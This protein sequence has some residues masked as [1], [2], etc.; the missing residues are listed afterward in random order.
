MMLHNEKQ[1][2]GGEISCKMA[3]WNMERHSLC[4]DIIKMN[5]WGI[6]REGGTLLELIQDRING[7]FGVSGLTDRVTLKE[8]QFFL[9]RK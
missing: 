8:L 9:K 3:S 7:G 2:F 4:E 6:C 1:N 5:Y